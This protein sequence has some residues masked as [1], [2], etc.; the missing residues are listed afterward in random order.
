M[1]R[2]LQEGVEGHQQQKHAQEA[3]KRE[4]NPSVLSKLGMD[5]RHFMPTEFAATNK[6]DRKSIIQ[7]ISS[8]N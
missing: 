4:V 7:E 6:N 3:V 5:D 1:A 8:D 2:G